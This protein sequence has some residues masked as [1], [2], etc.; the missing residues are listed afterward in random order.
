MCEFDLCGKT[1]SFAANRHKIREKL[2]CQKDAANL[3]AL[4]SECN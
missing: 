4:K 3:D 2:F 1:P